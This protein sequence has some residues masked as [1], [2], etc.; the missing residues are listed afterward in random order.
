MQSSYPLAEQSLCL[1][2]LEQKL[3]EHSGRQLSSSTRALSSCNTVSSTCEHPT[4]GLFSVG[5]ASAN[6]GV[7]DS[8]S[9]FIVV[10]ASATVVLDSS[11]LGSLLVSSSGL[12][13]SLV[14]TMVGGGGAVVSAAGNAKISVACN[15]CVPTSMHVPTSMQLFLTSFCAGPSIAVLFIRNTIQSVSAFAVIIPTPGT[16]TIGAHLAAS[17]QIQL[18]PILTVACSCTS[19]RV[20]WPH[21]GARRCGTSTP[22]Q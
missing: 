21:A 4:T 1:V 19:G 12:V 9:A 14:A 6:S 22:E 13:S 16:R 15:P 7:E 18:R 17:T 8:V 2:P 20:A 10:E 5:S 3:T 11:V